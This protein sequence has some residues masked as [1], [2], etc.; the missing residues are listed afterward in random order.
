[1]FHGTE[2]IPPIA[3]TLLAAPAAGQGLTPD[4]RTE[5]VHGETLRK[6]KVAS[7]ALDFLKDHAGFKKCARSWRYADDV[8]SD[9]RY[10]DLSA[11]DAAAVAEIDGRKAE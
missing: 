8:G 9:P 3:L 11:R 10:P 5:V 7:V 4:Q 2:R 1:M 6:G